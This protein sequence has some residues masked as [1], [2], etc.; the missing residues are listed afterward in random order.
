MSKICCGGV[1]DQGA[2]TNIYVGLRAQSKEEPLLD[3]GKNPSSA[4]YS[5]GQRERPTTKSDTS[6]HSME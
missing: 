5:R 1:T 6:G 3:H 2:H 4:R